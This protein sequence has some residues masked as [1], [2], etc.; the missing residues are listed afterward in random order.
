MQGP[1]GQ[2]EEEERD[3][4]RSSARAQQITR[5]RLQHRSGTSISSD[6]TMEEGTIK[7]KRPKCRLY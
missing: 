5:L 3:V 1:G 6:E 4:G 2:E 7:T